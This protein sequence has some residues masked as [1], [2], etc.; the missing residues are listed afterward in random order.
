MYGIGHFPAD[1]HEFTAAT[2]HQPRRR[3]VRVFQ[4][5]LT[6]AEWIILRGLPV[7]RPSR[8]ASDLLYDNEDPTGVAQIISDALRNVYDYPSTMAEALAP[9]A[10]RFGLRRHDGVALLR[11]MLDLVSD[12]ETNL[13]MSEARAHYGD[14]IDTERAP[15]TV[16]GYPLR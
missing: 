14:K 15:A 16:G 11:L 4:R 12:P 7:T 10:G 6:D 13:W 5:K 9:H 8:I 1:R 2:R 3:D